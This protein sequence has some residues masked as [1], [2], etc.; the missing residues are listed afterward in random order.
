MMVPIFTLN[1]SAEIAT[2]S[3]VKNARGYAMRAALIALLLTIASQAAGAECGNL[4]DNIWWKTA[5]EADVQAELGSGADLMART[6]FGSTPLHKAVEWGTTANIPPLLAAG[7]DVMA[8][9]KNGRTPLHGAA[10]TGN[11]VP[12]QAL[13]EAGADVMARDEDGSTPLHRAAKC[14]YRCERGAIQALLDAGA[15]AKATNEDGK[16][17]WDLAQRNYKLKGSEAYWVLADASLSCSRLCDVSWWENASSIDLQ[18]Q[19]DAGAF[20][21]LTDSERATTWS[22]A[23]KSSLKGTKGYWALN[24]AQYN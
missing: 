22:L 10:Q 20:T 3:I 4:C 5:T 18:A 7:A 15:D 11:T 12:T 21:K 8:R 2:V 13:L 9:D 16:T 6:E 19:L 14:R 1:I 23:E 17:P 24:D